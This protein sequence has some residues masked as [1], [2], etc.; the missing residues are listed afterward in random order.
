MTV[1]DGLRVVEIAGLGPTPFAAMWLADHGADVIRITRPGARHVLGLERD[2][3]DRGRDWLELD[4]KSPAGV[5]TARRLITRADAMIEGMRPGVM[6]RLG[7]GPGDFPENPRLVYGRMTGWGQ[8]G[9]L[10]HSAGHDLTYLAITGALHAIGP[11][12]HPVPP[13]NLLGDFAGGSMYLV[14]GMLAAIW[15]AQRTGQGQVVDAAISDGVAHLMAMISGMRAAGAWHDRRGANLLDGAAPYYT[16]YECAD[17]RHLAIGAI[18]P[19]FWA[20]LLHHLGIDPADLPDRADPGNWPAIRARLA[21]IIVT[22]SRDDWAALLEGTDACAAPVL[23]MDEAPHHPHMAARG[24]Y[25]GAEP[26]PAPR[27]SASP[28]TLR[29]GRAIAAAQALARWQG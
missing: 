27:L 26:A 20:E 15:R 3:L 13:L 17:G 21:A 23:S 2:V 24:S 6:E 29:Q 22:R 18:E 7:L 10:A 28:A 8:H 9:P 25:A 4:L 5:A 11:A 14:A 1:L 19:Q 12:D 16:V